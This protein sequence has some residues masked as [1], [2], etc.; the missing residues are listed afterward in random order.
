M[1]RMKKLTSIGLVLA[2]T[3][4]LL[5]KPGA[6]VLTP[7]STWPRFLTLSSVTPATAGMATAPAASSAAT[8]KSFIFISS[9]FLS[10]S[11][12]S[13]CVPALRGKVAAGLRAS[14]TLSLQTLLQTPSKICPTSNHEQPTYFVL[15][16]NA[17]QNVAKSRVRSQK[18]C[19]AQGLANPRVT[20]ADSSNSRSDLCPFTQSCFPFS[21]SSVSAPF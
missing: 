1:K 20:M 4:G 8:N 14:M 19:K 18:A 13:A 16:R 10:G 11:S 7:Q 2:M 15:P 6:D 12:C 5:E 3:V 21:S 17:P 9:S